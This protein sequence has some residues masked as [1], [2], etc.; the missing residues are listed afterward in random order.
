[1]PQK[2][3]K[4][5]V[6]KNIMFNN[7]L[8]ALL[9]LFSTI[10]T[11]TVT[12][13]TEVFPEPGY[14]WPYVATSIFLWVGYF[15][16]LLKMSKLCIFGI[17]GCYLYLYVIICSIVPNDEAYYM[18]S[19]TPPSTIPSTEF[20]VLRLVYLSFIVI[21]LLALFRLALRKIRD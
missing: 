19:L 6:G 13:W 11:A 21:A 14:S 5:S 18:R 1:M 17:Y 12:P 4:S 7:L 2:I 9:F 3:G 8:T 16:W 10:A 15:G 20:L